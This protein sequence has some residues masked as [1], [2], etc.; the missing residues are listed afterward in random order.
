MGYEN[1]L[2]TKVLATHCACCGRPLVDAKSVQIGLGPIC[3]KTFQYDLDVP[4]KDRARANKIIYELALAV[5]SSL[6]SLK[7]LRLTA[8]LARLGFT[9]IAKIFLYRGASVSIE[10]REIE[11]EERYFVRAPYN[12][13]FNEDSYIPGRYGV[14]VCSGFSPSKRKVF[15]WVFPKTP[16]ARRCL[17]QALLKHHKGALAIGPQGPFKIGSLENNDP[18]NEEVR[19]SA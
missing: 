18:K 2:Q 16:Q 6:I 10:L 3:R 1:A 8:E 5:S 4:D 11:G 13:E 12:P 14:K 17:W 9:L 15:H 7:T 19:N